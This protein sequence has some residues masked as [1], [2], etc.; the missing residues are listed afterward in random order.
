MLAR[1]LKISVDGIPSIAITPPGG[2]QN[3]DYSSLQGL[4]RTEIIR[5]ASEGANSDQF[6]NADI[7]VPFGPEAEG[8]ETYG[9]ISD[10]L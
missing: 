3:W 4:D 1:T 7:F 5:A 2:D 10:I 9:S 6:P 8:G